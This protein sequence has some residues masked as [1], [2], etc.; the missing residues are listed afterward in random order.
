MT[1]P[2][3]P[4]AP[5]ERRRADDQRQRSLF[6]D[7]V[8]GLP[9]LAVVL[10]EVRTM[11]D[12][13]RQVGVLHVEVSDLRLVESLYG[14]QVF[15]RI[16]A[17][18]ATA[19]VA[20]VGKALPA[21]T[22]VAIDAIAGARLLAFVPCGDHG[23]EV[24]AQL[25]TRLSR[26]TRSWTEQAFEGGEFDGL[27]PEIRVQVGHALLAMTPFF[28]FERSV[29]VAV[30]RARECDR[31]RE[32]LRD[33]SWAEELR[34]II[35]CADI[36]SVFQPIVRLGGVVEELGQEAFVRGP[37]GSA[38]ELPRPMF[39]FST[40]LGTCRQLDQ[41]C[42]E[43]AIRAFAA[44]GCS[45]RL[46]VNVVPETLD[47][48]EWFEGRLPALLRSLAIE[49][50]TLVLDLP[51]RA[52]EADPVGFCRRAQRCR[53]EGLAIAVDDMGTGRVPRSLL[54]TIRPDYF[55]FDPSLVREV[56]RSPMVEDALSSV[57]SFAKQLGAE[58]IGEGIER[59]SQ[60]ETLS[61]IGAKWGQGYLFAAPAA[62]ERR[63]AERSSPV[64]GS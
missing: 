40:R 1:A 20:A 31:Q 6:E 34:R 60:A 32:A 17:L 51:E 56:D 22:R 5:S 48:G 13:R 11:L 21:G 25:L 58:V 23:T 42:A 26:Q 36:A 7:R 47:D 49:P 43:A 8:T 30:D 62:L 37:S 39:A 2:H 3:D 54:E 38:F 44:R 19:L 15:D 33:L 35:R 18:A 46:F 14:W 61:R 12:S 9:V 55:K 53:D 64:A 63:A 4:T 52:A 57:A 16:M 28:R 29:Y 41:L 45:G 59:A 50:A 27:S 10:D 24:D